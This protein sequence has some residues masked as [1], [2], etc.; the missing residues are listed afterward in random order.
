MENTGSTPFSGTNTQHNLSLKTIF[1]DE[2]NSMACAVQ[3]LGKNL[4]EMAELAAFKNLSLAFEETLEETKTQIERLDKI[5]DLLDIKSSEENCLA[6]KCII[7]EAYSAVKK[8]GQQTFRRDMALI[9]YAQI[10]E[11]IEI[12]SY[13]ML[14]T[15]AVKLGY[16]E[17]HALL[18]ESLDE[19]KDTKKLLQLIADEYIL[20]A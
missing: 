8:T 2:L 12:A 10:I 9:F 16:E 17:A 13:N 7:D 6:M 20:K 14:K 5:F 19:A 11:H 15:I 18:G 3:H 1:E 4:P